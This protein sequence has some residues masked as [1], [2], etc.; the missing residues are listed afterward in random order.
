MVLGESLYEQ[1]NEAI[2][3]WYHNPP[4]QRGSDLYVILIADNQSVLLVLKQ[5]LDMV[6]KCLTT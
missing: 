6:N 3:E 4:S 5:D 2:V 1:L